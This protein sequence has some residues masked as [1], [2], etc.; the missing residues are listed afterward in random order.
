MGRA[1]RFVS[2][3]VVFAVMA[4]DGSFKRGMHAFGE[5]ERVAI[6]FLKNNAAL[7]MHKTRHVHHCR[8]FTSLIIA[9]A[10]HNNSYAIRIDDYCLAYI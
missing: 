4:I 6:R 1:S 2:T 3:D 5:Q 7:K 8:H 10:L 9:T